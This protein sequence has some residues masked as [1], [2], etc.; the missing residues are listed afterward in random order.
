MPSKKSSSRGVRYTAEQKAAIV[1]F[2]LKHNQEHGRG[3]Q[4]A[5]VRKYGV[6]PL[7]IGAWI[8][9]SGAEGS[10]VKANA[11][12]KNGGSLSRRVADL[13]VVGRQIEALEFEL[14][15]LRTKLASLKSHL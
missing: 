7:S 6:S 3:G 14:K 13:L 11:V 12:P 2:V 1:D 15:G 10:G 4:S 8:G 5:A 9:G